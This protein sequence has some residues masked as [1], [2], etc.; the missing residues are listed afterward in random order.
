MLLLVLAAAALVTLALVCL[1]LLRGAE[2]VGDRGQFD[3][4]VYRDQLRE[5]ERDVTRGVLSPAEAESA[6]LE[7]QRRLLG[8][9]AD[10]HGGTI[11]AS[12]D[13]KLAVGIGVLLVCGS[14][15]L[16]IQLGS[17][18]LPDVPFTSR[19]TSSGVADAGHVDIRAAAARLAEQLKGDPNNAQGWLLYAR[20][21]SLLSN[22]QKAGEA[23]R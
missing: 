21:E 7:I 13:P 11:R 23:Y 8:V 18:S 2:A 6:R 17:P 15:G 20:A 5:V 9:S 3:R 1:P 19:S 14:A 4:A 16:Y 12:R 22:W 10:V